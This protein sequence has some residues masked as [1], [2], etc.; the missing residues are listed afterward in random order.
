MAC[1]RCKREVHEASPSVLKDGWIC[2][3]KNGLCLRKN[4]R[5]WV[6][7]FGALLCK[8]VGHDW[9]DPLFCWRCYQQ[10]EDWQER[11]V[12]YYESV[13][14]GMN[15]SAKYLREKKSRES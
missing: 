9:T 6:Q 10:H 13:H 4:P 15:H 14:G 2:Y 11:V 12:T 7:F 3:D 5:P 1:L 8:L